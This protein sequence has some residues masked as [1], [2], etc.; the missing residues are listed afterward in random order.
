MKKRFVALVAALALGASGCAASEVTTSPD[1]PGDEAPQQ[2]R[3]VAKVG[4]RITLKGTDENLKVAITVLKPPRTVRSTD[5]SKPTRKGM[6]F[7]GVQ[8]ALENVGTAVYDDSLTNGSVLLDAEGQKYNTI[9]VTEIAAG[10]VVD[11]VKMAPG[12]KRKGYLVFEAPKG[13][14]P[15][16]LQ[17]ALDSGMAPQTG[18]WALG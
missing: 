10:P 1:L 9:L 17:I 11:L 15:V 7:V 3:Q 12:K 14:R 8:L 4:D 13:V 6:R 16:T 18:E 5:G 2:A